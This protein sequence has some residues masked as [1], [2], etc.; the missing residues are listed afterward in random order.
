VTCVCS[1]TVAYAGRYFN[2][3]EVATLAVPNSTNGTTY[4]ID[5]TNGSD[6]NNGTTIGTAFK[7]I[8]HAIGDGNRVRGGNVFKIK[9]GTYHEKPQF[10]Y[11]SPSTA[12]NV[13]EAHRIVVGP[14]GDGEV[15]IDASDTNTL[16]WSVYSGNSNIYK[17]PCDLKINSSS[18]PPNAVIMNDNFRSCRPVFNLS[19]VTSFGKWYWDSSAKTIY[20]YTGGLTPASQNILVTSLDS[21]NSYVGFNP[22]YTDYLTIYGITLMGASAYGMTFF[23][24]HCVV[25]NCTIK[26]S[27]KAAFKMSAG[28]LGKDSTGMNEAKAIKNHIYGNVMMNWPR[29]HSAGQSWDING[30]WPSAAAFAGVLNGLVSGNIIHDNGGEGFITGGLPGNAI[31]EDNI[32]YDNWSV[33]LYIESQGGSIMRRNLTYSTSGGTNVSDIAS[34]DDPNLHGEVIESGSG[35]ITYTNFVHAVNKRM[36]PIC[37]STADETSSNPASVNNKVYDN[38]AIGCYV[39]FSHECESTNSRMKDYVIANNTIIMPTDPAPTGYQWTGIRLLYCAGLN[40]GTIVKNNIVYNTRSDSPMVYLQGGT[41]ETGINLDY[42]SYY[43]P[44]NNTVQFAASS[45]Y[46]FSSWKS[47]MTG[48]DVHSQFTNPMLAGGATHV[49]TSY[50]PTN[51]SPIKNAGLTISGITTD[52]NNTSFASTPTIGALEVNNSRYFDQSAVPTLSIPNSTTGTTYYIDG[53]NGSDSNNGTLGSPFKTISYA[54]DHN[55]GRLIAGNVFKIKAGTYH[56]RLDLSGA[57]SGTDD[58]HRIVIGPYGDGEVILDATTTNALTWQVHNSNIYKANCDL[59][60]GSFH[61]APAAVV[62]NDNFKSCRQVF[63][64]TD[65]NTFGKWYWDSSAKVIY[66]YTGGLTPASQNILVTSEDDGS[67]Y[68]A[69]YGWYTNYLT[70]YGLTFIGAPSSAFYGYGSNITI[71]NCTFKYSNKAAIYI[72]GG[73]NPKILNNHIYGN[74]LDNWP[75]G[76]KWNISAGWPSAI[77]LD[78]SPTGLVSGNI[79]HD[80]GGEGVVSGSMTGSCTIEDNIVYNNWS[81]NIYPIAQS[82]DVIRRNLTYAT[83]PNVSDIVSID[84]PTLS[85]VITDTGAGF[86]TYAQLYQ[87]VLRRMYPVCISN[88]IEGNNGAVQPSNQIYDNIAIGCYQGIQND[89]EATGS[90]FPNTVIANNTII[91][92]TDSPPTG[93]TWTGIS[94]PYCSGNNTGSIVKNNVITNTRTESF[95]LFLE[96]GTNEIGKTSIDYNVYYNP[97]TITNLTAYAYPSNTNY[98][99]TNW[100]SAMSQDTHSTFVAP[101]FIGGTANDPASYIPI[102]GSPL[103]NSGTSVTNVTTDFNNFTKTTPLTI[104]AL[105]YGSYSG[106]ANPFNDTTPPVTTASPTS[107]TYISTQTVTLSTDESATIYYTTNG[108]TPTIGGSTTT[109][110]TTPISISITTTLKYFAKDTAGNIETV[111]TLVYTINSIIPS[112]MGR[113]QFKGKCRYGFYN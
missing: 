3:S 34:V 33:N 68:Y 108:D 43:N 73:S 95:L 59:M 8:S 51:G 2:Q 93:Y 86:M 112:S 71:Q 70:I 74:I 109:V 15:I 113:A 44:N 11:V 82:G 61:V 76:H 14:Y 81:V 4:Y 45:N 28:D 83:T 39:G 53:V 26:Y 75:R 56:E 52:F 20:V 96:G 48:Q 21:Y 90:G 27:G 19:D 104:G 72:V 12:G 106:S 101:N 37:L 94:L 38:I 5:G 67:S 50:I 32:A 97:N 58:A 6:S 1:S 91:M 7:T 40:S 29:G 30:G 18:V 110:Y 65:V 22:Y 79:I 36:Y 84:D 105:D 55:S 31:L 63:N 23:G 89:C 57:T 107:G 25:E 41:S 16:T 103:I 100:K 92:P 9:A 102:L 99:L 13:D 80:N 54:T 62:M 46:S 10:A 69:V 87:G 35:W 60:L 88:G 66:V 64:L 78:G 47:T 98:T 17:A 42:N 111:K 77:A 24:E 85:G 49:P